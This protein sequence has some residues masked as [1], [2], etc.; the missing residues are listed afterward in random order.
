MI[1]AVKNDINDIKATIRDILCREL[2][3]DPQA[4]ADQTNLRE[5]P[6]IESLKILRIILRI[7]EHYD[8]ELE[9]QVVFSVETIENIAVAVAN[10]LAKK[11]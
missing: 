3:L 11:I 4:I 5:I 1:R 2:K 10:L 6:G 8:I 9:E 7:E